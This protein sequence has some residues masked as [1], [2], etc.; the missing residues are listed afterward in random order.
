MVYLARFQFASIANDASSSPLAPREG[1]N[2]LNFNASRFCTLLRFLSRAQ[3]PIEEPPAPANAS[4]NRARY[5]LKI[6]FAS[7][8]PTIEPP[9]H[10]ALNARWKAPLG[11]LISLL[12]LCRP[13]PVRR[14]SAVLVCPRVHPLHPCS[15]PSTTVWVAG[16]FGFDALM[17]KFDRRQSTPR[18]GPGGRP[19]PARQARS[20]RPRLGTQ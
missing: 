2:L 3:R 4:I 14:F 1:S 5:R 9:A 15:G 18:G 20:L 6:F 13:S 10:F 7:N 19:P 8:P 16:R 11:T 17:T 12:A